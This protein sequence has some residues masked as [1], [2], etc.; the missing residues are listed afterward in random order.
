V[1]SG[2]NMDGTTMAAYQDIVSSKQF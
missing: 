2:D 1:F